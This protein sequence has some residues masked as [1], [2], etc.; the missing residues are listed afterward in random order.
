MEGKG[1]AWDKEGEGKKIGMMVRGREKGWV[2]QQKEGI[3]EK[4]GN[5][6]REMVKNSLNGLENRTLQFLQ[7]RRIY[8]IQLWLRKI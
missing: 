8:S 2:A 6:E 1:V 3:G 4:D 5:G 7:L